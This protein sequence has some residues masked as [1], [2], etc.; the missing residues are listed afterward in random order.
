MNSINYTPAYSSTCPS[1]KLSK[2]FCVWWDHLSRA[3]TTWVDSICHTCVTSKPNFAFPLKCAS[4]EVDLTPTWSCYNGTNAAQGNELLKKHGD[5]TN[6]IDLS[7]VPSI[8]IDN[9]SCFWF[10]SFSKCHQKF[11]SERRQREIKNFWVTLGGF[12]EVLS[13]LRGIW[14]KYL[15]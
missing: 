14:T 10:T 2:L 7:F 1:R 8:E 12:S 6:T 9:V 11:W 3:S 13:Y 15:S 4:S 5:Q